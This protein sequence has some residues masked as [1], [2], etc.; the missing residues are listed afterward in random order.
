MPRYIDSHAHITARGF[1]GDRA[2]VLARAFDA[3]VS[4][5]V[6]PATNLDD[7]RRALELAEQYPQVY[8]C[9]GIHPH[10]ASSATDQVLSTIEELSRHPRVVAIGEIGLDFH[11]N[12]SPADVQERVFRAQLMIARAR[13]LPVVIHTRESLP[14]TI[15][16][17]KEAVAVAPEWRSQE[18]AP[19]ARYPSPRGVFHCFPGTVDDAW[20]VIRLGFGISFPGI[21]TFKNAAQAAAVASGVSLEHFLLETDSPYLAPVPYRGTRNEPAHVVRVAEKLAELQHLSLEDVARVTNYSAYRIFG[22]GK[23]G[24]PQITYTLKDAL[25]I[26]PTIR[27]DADCVFCDRKGDAIIKG[28]NLRIEREPS[29]D[30]II[31]E[32]ADPTK[33]SEIVFCGYGEPTIRLDVVM[34]VSRW[35]K[36]HGGKTRLNT[37]GHGN[38]I[39]KRNIVP[40]LV[41]LIDAV[42]ISLNSTDPKQYGELMRIDGERFFAAMVEF[43]KECVKLLPR[44]VMTVVDI[45]A[46]DKEKARRLVEQEIG[47]DFQIRPFF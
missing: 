25:Y 14:Q 9:V 23:A 17:I 20:S 8:A 37:D 42:S 32:I 31:R 22:I 24:E 30:D 34:D 35:V 10:E 19:P 18:S 16:I 46:V 5:V 39:N 2:D 29:A 36:A 6:N 28:H 21:I 43:A 45:D 15:S 40:E 44:V 7:S 1:D 12:F 47:A 13:N 26:N 33:Y 38:I 41:G 11:Y 4:Y 27:C 3:G